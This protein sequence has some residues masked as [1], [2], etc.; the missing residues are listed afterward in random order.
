MRMVICIALLLSVDNR[1]VYII[2]VM[3]GEY[4][5]CCFKLSTDV[6]LSADEFCAPCTTFKIV[7]KREGVHP[8]D[9]TS[10]RPLTPPRPPARCPRLISPHPTPIQIIV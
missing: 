6:S 5:L 1:I 7:S 10:K 4:I 3:S 2:L 8:P 9:R